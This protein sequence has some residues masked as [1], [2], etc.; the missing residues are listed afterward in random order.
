MH[1]T[2][3]ASRTWAPIDLRVD[4]LRP[5]RGKHFIATGAHRA[6][7]NR[8]AVTHMELEN[9]AG[10]LIATGGAAYMVG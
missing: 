3:A 10:E 5:G 9:D 4:Y 6:L 7:G 2:P 1:R 8:I